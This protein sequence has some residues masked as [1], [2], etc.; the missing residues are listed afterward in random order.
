MVMKNNSLEVKRKTKPKKSKGCTAQLLISHCSMPSL[1][2]SP[3]QPL[4]ANTLQV[5]H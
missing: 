1:F 3:D 4:R 5:T 2:L